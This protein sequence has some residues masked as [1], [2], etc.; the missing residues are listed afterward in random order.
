MILW[1]VWV[2]PLFATWGVLCAYTLKIRFS[3][4]QYFFAKFSLCLAFNGFFAITYLGMIEQHQFLLLGHQPD[5]ISNYPFIGW[6]AF[7][8][9]PIHAGA[10][11]V[12]WE[13]RWWF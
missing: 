11:P 13:I 8:C 7:F 6:I 2:F 10:L 12:R 4:T 5:L 9:I 3:G 1:F